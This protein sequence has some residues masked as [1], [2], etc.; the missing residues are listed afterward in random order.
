M[1]SDSTARNARPAR[2]EEVA[3]LAKVS[4]ATAARALSDSDLVTPATKQRVREAAEALNYRVNALARAMSA[5]Q[6]KTIGLVIADISNSFFDLATRAIVDTAARD[7]YQVLVVNTNESLHAEREAIRILSEKRVDGLILV[8]CSPDDYAHLEPHRAPVP[9]LVLVDRRIVDLDVPSV[10][11]DDFS[12]ARDAVDLF[13]SR[14]HRRIALVVNTSDD[15]VYREGDPRSTLST[16]YDRVRGYHE[17]LRAHGIEPDPSLVRYVRPEHSSAT[18]AITQLLTM[19]DAPSAVLT[20]NSDAALAVLDASNLNSLEIG[21]DL[22]VITFDDAPWAR[23][24]RP[25]LSVV[26]RPVYK[27]GSSAVRL[28]MEQLGPEHTLPSSVELRNTLVDRGSVQVV[29]PP[30]TAQRA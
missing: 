5:G 20:T 12:G 17:G 7:G 23:V 2:L 25:P 4:K 13:A 28:L 11:T 26:Q 14:G 27:L 3:E 24:F 10:S 16:I 18:S 30:V 15:R 6:T 22:S 21:K 1:S 8:P 19:P 9:P 29:G